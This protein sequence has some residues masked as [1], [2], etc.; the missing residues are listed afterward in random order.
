MK[1]TLRTALAQNHSAARSAL[2]S[3]RKMVGRPTHP[4]VAL[5]KNLKQEDFRDLVAQFGPEAAADFIK[6]M[7]SR[8]LQEEGD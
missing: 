2:V 1:A 8:L 7:E 6:E 5:Y 4:D 3:A